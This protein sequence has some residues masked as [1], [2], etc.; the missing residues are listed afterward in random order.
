MLSA[1]EVSLPET[2][3]RPHGAIRS[4]NNDVL[5]ILE[6][7]KLVVGSWLMVDGDAINEQRTTNQ[8]NW[9]ISSAG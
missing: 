4:L 9:G 8:L 2:T 6:V 1:V 5:E 7:G 3:N